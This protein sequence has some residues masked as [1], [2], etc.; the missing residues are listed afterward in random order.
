MTIQKFLIPFEQSNIDHVGPDF[1]TEIEQADGSSIFT[2]APELIE[3]LGVKIGD[4][5]EFT[6]VLDEEN[7]KMEFNI[8]HQGTPEFLAAFPNTETEN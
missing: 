5:V 1:V 3:M 8:L 4:F 2:F 7:P 6:F